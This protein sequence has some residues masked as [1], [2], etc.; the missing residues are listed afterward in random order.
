MATEDFSYSNGALQTVSS[1]V[2]TPG[3]AYEGVDVQIL[4]GQIA[5][6]ATADSVYSA[7]RAGFLQG[8]DLTGNWSIEF[9]TTWSDPGI[10]GRD[11][12]L[13][14]GDADGA[15]HY[16]YLEFH[17]IDPGPTQVHVTFNGDGASP[18]P[19]NIDMT[20][21]VQ[22]VF[23]LE[24]RDGHTLFFQDGTLITDQAIPIFSATPATQ[25][26]EVAFR[27]S[28]LTSPKWFVDYIRAATQAPDDG[29]PQEHPQGRYAPG[30]IR[31]LLNRL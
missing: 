20:G 11:F 23:R 30:R 19:V 1:G 2:W 21:G 12:D 15:Q 8:I 27:L 3:I 29:A 9:A 10:D 25:D 5:S 16:F 14:L 24:Q 18:F 7:H 4:D 28:T 13:L 31:R 17:A 26:I 6:T 22:Y